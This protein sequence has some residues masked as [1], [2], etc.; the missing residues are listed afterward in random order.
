MKTVF[1]GKEKIRFYFWL[2]M[3][4]A[5]AI[6]LSLNFG[7]HWWLG[8]AVISYCR[9][10][11]G[12]STVLLRQNGLA[13]LLA[14]LIFSCAAPVVI[15]FVAQVY[16]FV[17]LRSWATANQLAFPSSLRRVA[18]ELGLEHKIIL[19]RST[20]TAVFAGGF[21]SPRIYL[22]TGLLKLLSVRELRAVLYHESHHVSRR[23]PLK[24]LLFS[25]LRRGFWFLPMTSEVGESLSLWRELAAD[26][27]A[28][29]KMG[30]IRPVLTALFKIIDNGAGRGAELPGAAFGGVHFSGCAHF[31]ALGDRVSYLVNDKAHPGLPFFSR[32]LVISVASV[33]LLGFLYILPASASQEM[34][35][36]GRCVDPINYTPVNSTPAK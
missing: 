10:M 18:Q 6:L 28:K 26:L 1:S 5:S 31:A 22:T 23:D 11:L 21:V 8:E 13:Y 7:K 36:L 9:E 4:A 35:T 32:R 17:R 34:T 15:N 3:L 16:R 19:V 24:M 20:Y 2:A 12:N 25:S 33:A 27:A 29:E 30:T 14:I